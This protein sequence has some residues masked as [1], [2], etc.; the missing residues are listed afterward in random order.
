MSLS[1]F[2][3]Y[4][5]VQ[6]GRLKTKWI[7]SREVQVTW[8]ENQEFPQEF[9]YT[10]KERGELSEEELVVY[11]KYHYAYMILYL[12]PLL[13]LGK[14]MKELNQEASS[15]N[16]NQFKGSRKSYGVYWTGQCYMEVEIENEEFRFQVPP[17]FIEQTGYRAGRC[18]QKDTN[19]QRAW[20]TYLYI[21]VFAELKRRTID[22]SSSSAQSLFR[23]K[24]GYDATEQ[25]ISEELYH[26]YDKSQA[27]LSNMI[28]QSKTDFEVEDLRKFARAATEMYKET[29]VF[30]IQYLIYFIGRDQLVL[31]IY[32]LFTFVMETSFSKFPL[33]IEY[34]M[35]MRALKQEYSAIEIAYGLHELG[36]DDD[37]ST[38]LIVRLLEVAGFSEEQ[39]NKALRNR[40]DKSPPGSVAASVATVGSPGSATLGLTELYKTPDSSVGSSAF[41][42]DEG[43]A[44][45][46]DT[47]LQRQLRAHPILARSR[48]APQIPAPPQLLNPIRQPLGSVGSAAENCATGVPWK[49]PR[50]RNTVAPKPLTSA[51]RFL[52][53]VENSGTF[54][55]LDP[56]DPSIFRGD[57]KSIRDA[58][59][60][61]KGGERKAW[62]RGAQNDRSTDVRFAFYPEL[63]TDQA[64]VIQECDPRTDHR[65][66][67]VVGS[68]RRE[69]NRLQTAYE[70][71]RLVLRAPP[72]PGAKYKL[73]LKQSPSRDNRPGLYTP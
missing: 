41:R 3:V 19:E 40:T 67:T 55:E 30:N 2:P 5:L 54:T 43:S 66:Y 73:G 64:L 42:T 33:P 52:F 20:S 65:W 25:A 70:K 18:P 4:D 51:A 71:R 62:E 10:K 72:H 63:P 38:D 9:S 47:P 57:W 61:E 50:Q 46:G 45:L 14:T 23:D 48:G 27:I 1:Q 35:V 21:R 69:K 8:G 36:Y 24:F 26:A 13:R 12:V 31:L 29:G 60:R 59:Y 7:N 17:S 58:L 34:Y 22:G 44:V 68:S 37:G 32:V 28:A 53:T 56:V 11:S 15:F 6:S 39:I 49:T 16:A